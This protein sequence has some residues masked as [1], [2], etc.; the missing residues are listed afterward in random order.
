MRLRIFEGEETPYAVRMAIK[1]LVHKA[2][3]AE[4][5]AKC[6]NAWAY[7]LCH[8]W[9]DHQWQTRPQGPERNKYPHLISDAEAD[10]IMAQVAQEAMEPT[11][12][13]PG[14]PA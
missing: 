2:A 3:L 14:K 9:P 7:K 12:E 8:A 13:D 10:A 1:A 11:T 6:A 5:H 4:E